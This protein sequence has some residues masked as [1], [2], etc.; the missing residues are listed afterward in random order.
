LCFTAILF[1]S[2][3]RRYF[4][5]KGK[6]SEHFIPYFFLGV[7]LCR[8]HLLILLLIYSNSND[9]LITFALF[10][11]FSNQIIHLFWDWERRHLNCSLCDSLFSC[12]LSYYEGKNVLLY[13]NMIFLLFFGL[14]GK[15]LIMSRNLITSITVLTMKIDWFNS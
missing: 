15:M 9:S 8:S 1:Y 2:I 11:E 4:D 7:G 5:W 12:F 10:N 14:S 13:S 6:K 3:K